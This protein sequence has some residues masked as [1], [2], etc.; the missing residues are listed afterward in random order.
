M[1]WLEKS[2]AL[3]CR[4]RPRSSNADVRG[5]DEG[6]FGQ[7]VAVEV[8]GTD[9]VEPAIGATDGR[10]FRHQVQFRVA[11]GEHGQGGAGIGARAHD[12]HLVGAI[13]V[14]V[15]QPGAPVLEDR[16]LVQFESHDGPVAGPHMQSRRLD[17]VTQD[18]VAIARCRAA[19]HAVATSF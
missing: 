15:A 18:A 19:S 10:R 1:V 2:G 14:E 8:R 13:M 17:C 3:I 5:L 16:A 7:S 4:R 9:R 11:H 6:D 12:Q